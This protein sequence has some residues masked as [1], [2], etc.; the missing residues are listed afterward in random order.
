MPLNGSETNTPI[1]PYISNSPPPPNE[2][3]LDEAESSQDLNSL[4]K[5][6]DLSNLSSELE[7]SANISIPIHVIEEKSSVGSFEDRPIFDVD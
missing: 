2:L 7:N 6:L 1:T 5:P 4:Q 3:L